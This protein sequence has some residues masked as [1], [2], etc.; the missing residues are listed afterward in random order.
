VNI[1]PLDP[2]SPSSSLHPLL[3]L[4][5]EY[6]SPR[7]CLNTLIAREGWDSLFKGSI[8][9]CLV[10]VPLYALTF[11]IFE[12]L[13]RWVKPGTFIGLRTWQQDLDS[14]RKSRFLAMQNKLKDEYGLDVEKMVKA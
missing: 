10:V 11:V 8:V 14:V 6:K 12:A 5:G 3:T 9:R 13:Q 1:S 2:A 4:P 7:S